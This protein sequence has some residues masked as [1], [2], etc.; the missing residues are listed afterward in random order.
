M[1]RPALRPAEAVPPL[2]QRYARYGWVAAAAAGAAL[3]PNLGPAGQEF[4]FAIV[5]LVSAGCVVAGVRTHRPASVLAW[6]LLAAALVCGGSASLVWGVQFSLHQP[7]VSA[8]S[9]VDVLY[10]AMY[11]LMAAGLAFR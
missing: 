10:F 8:F 9:A 4:A 6:L 11:P 5:G 3:A 1:A 2:R 7:D